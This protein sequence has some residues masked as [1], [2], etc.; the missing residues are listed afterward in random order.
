M[1]L[2]DTALITVRHFDQQGIGQFA[3]DADG[4]YIWQLFQDRLINPYLFNKNRL[5]PCWMPEAVIISSLLY[6]VVPE[7]VM[8]STL[9]NSVSPLR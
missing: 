2:N 4:G 9:K 7:T 6:S 8:V 1:I 5:S 3:A